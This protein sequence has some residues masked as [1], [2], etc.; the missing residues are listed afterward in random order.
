M[1]VL[2]HHIYEYRK[3]IRRLVLHTMQSKCR[4]CAEQRLKDN[5]IFYWIQTVN[6]KT[7][8]VFFGD[9]ECVEVICSFGE[10]L[11]NQYTPEE[12]FI[13]GVLL[14]YDTTKQCQRY[15][16]MKDKGKADTNSFVKTCNL[17]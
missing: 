13:L 16:T 3:G 4:Q 6:E 8:N 9:R 5:D 14:G 12:D 2:S 1:Q 15:M 7:I 17:N 11:L 10:K